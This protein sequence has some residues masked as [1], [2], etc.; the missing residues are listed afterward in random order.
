M[1]TLKSILQ[2]ENRL[3]D[4]YIPNFEDLK[5]IVQQLKE[6]GWRIALT[7]GVWDMF[8]VGHGRYLAEARSYGDILIVGVDSDELTRKMKGPKRPFDIFEER[9]EVLSMLS[10]VN[11]ITRRDTDQDKYD[12]IK[13][14]RPDVLIMSKTTSSFT[15]QDKK[16]LSAFC[17]EI[18]H[19][20]AKAATSTTA[21]TLRLMSDGVEGLPEKIQK[22]INDH[23]KEIGV[24][25]E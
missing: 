18:K 12:L 7:Q 19:L 21:K 22:T 20:E 11:V 23:L 15:D 17:G 10:S 6:G 1:S 8:H 16:E 13:L 24:K 3:D 5:N 2:G 4:K 25:N 9:I 14:V